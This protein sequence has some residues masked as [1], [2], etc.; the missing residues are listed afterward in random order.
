MKYFYDTEF[1]EGTKKTW[2]GKTTPPTIDLISIGIVD[3]D[4]REYYSI[5]KEFDLDYAWDKWDGE[6]HEQST[7]EKSH[8]LSLRKKYWI[9]ENVLRPIFNELFERATNINSVGITMTKKRLKFLISR[10]GKSRKTIAKEVKNFCYSYKAVKDGGGQITSGSFIPNKQVEIELYGYYSS[11]DHVV[12]SWLFGR[13]IDL[14]KGFPMYTKDLKQMID[15]KAEE[16]INR[17]CYE[18]GNHTVWSKN[19]AI[20][21]IKRQYSYPKQENEHNALADAKWNYKLYKF[22]EKC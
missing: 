6:Y 2:W 14:P 12:L 9:R 19:E 16:T 7:F 18:S 17:I 21:F 4:G 22:L 13:M 11:C 10:Y 8:G 20:S 5:S 1:I 15:D 3:E